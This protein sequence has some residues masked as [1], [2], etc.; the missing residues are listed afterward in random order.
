MNGLS[1]SASAVSQYISCTM[2]GSMAVAHTM[3]E[4][5]YSG[6]THTCVLAF[7]GSFV[8]STATAQRRMTAL[9]GTGLGS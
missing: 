3:V 9:A 4:R 5:P 2:P 8:M 6:L 7:Q 1:G